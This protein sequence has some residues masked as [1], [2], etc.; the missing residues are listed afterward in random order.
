MAQNYKNIAECNMKLFCVQCEK[1]KKEAELISD[2]YSLCE[3]HYNQRL[4]WLNCKTCPK[5]MLGK[6]HRHIK[7]DKSVV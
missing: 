3:E 4:A 1:P 2:G 5:E 7:I 6:P